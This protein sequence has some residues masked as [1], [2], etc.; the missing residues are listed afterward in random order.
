MQ[1]SNNSNKSSQVKS[2][3]VKMSSKSKSSPVAPKTGKAASTSGM[4]YEEQIH[5]LLSQ[6]LYAKSSTEKI[7]FNTQVKTELGCYNGSSPYD[8]LCN[9][10][11]ANSKDLGIEIKKANAHDWVHC[12]LRYEGGTIVCPSDTSVR[13]IFSALLTG[14]TYWG[15]NVPTFMVKGKKI[16]P[17]EW[18]TE[19]SKFPEITFTIPEDTIA[20]L[21]AAK[22]CSYIHISKV[23]LFHTG[24]DVCGFGVPYFRCPQSLTVYIKNHG[25]RNKS[26]MDLS[27]SAA[28]HPTSYSDLMTARSRFSLDRPTMFPRKLIYLPSHPGMSPIAPVSSSV[29]VGGGASAITSSTEK[30]TTGASVTYASIAATKK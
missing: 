26:V 10:T 7:I 27:V 3:Q 5:A 21:Y 22:G 6:T 14:N 17:H 8:V 28:I 20:R 19:K 15:N 12:H 13:S 9:Q 4:K 25:S 11:G 24:V 23:G 16:T 29:V 2:S 30:T 1:Q 18:F